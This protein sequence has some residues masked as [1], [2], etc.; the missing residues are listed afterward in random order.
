MHN[1]IRNFPIQRQNSRCGRDR[2]V[3]AC[4]LVS[5]FVVHGRKLNQENQQASSKKGGKP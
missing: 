3:L 1:M 5:K 2:Q 4:C